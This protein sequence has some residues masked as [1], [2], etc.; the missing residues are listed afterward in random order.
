VTTSTNLKVGSYVLEALASDSS[1]NETVFSEAFNVSTNVAPLQ[2]RIVGPGTVSGPTNGEPLIVG[3]FLQLTAIPDPNQFFF[4]WSNSSGRVSL[5]PTQTFTNS[6]NLSVTA[7]FVTN[8]LPTNCVAF[9][10][11]PTN[12]FL[13]NGV[14]QL[15]GTVSTVSNLPSGPLSV[16]CQIFSGTNLL[17]ITR[18]R[19][20][21]NVGTN[22]A[23]SMGP[24][25]AGPCIAVVEAVDQAGNAT[26]VSNVFNAEVDLT[27][28][29]I[30][31]SS[32]VSPVFQTANLPIALTGNAADAHGLAALQ[33]ELFP[34][35][36]S[37]GTSPSGGG[38]AA[39][40][41]TSNWTYN[42]G[43]VPPGVYVLDAF[44][45][46]DLGNH[47][48]AAVLVTNTAVLIEGDGT[49]TLSQ[50]NVV[51]P[52]PVGYPLQTGKV[53]KMVATPA[54][55]Q[56]FV[57]WSEGAFAT[58]KST[59]TFT[60]TT[61]LLWTATF[62]PTNAKAIAISSPAANAKLKTNSFVVKGRVAAAFQSGSVKCQISSLTTGTNLLTV[63][64]TMSGANWSASIS[65]LPPDNY[66]LQ[67]TATNSAGQS[68]MDSERF[69]VL[70]FGGLAGTYTGLFLN[71]NEPV[72]PTNSGF[73]TFTLSPTGVMSGKIDFPAYQTIAI[74][75]ILVQNDFF[76]AGIMTFSLRNFH[77]GPLDG[78]INF[79][80]NGTSN[81]ATGGIAS[82]NWG[83]PLLCYQTVKTL[84]SSTAPATGKYVFTL[85]PVDQTNGPATN[86]YA[87]LTVS[88]NGALALNGALPD[89]TTF[90]E[91]GK[92]STNGVWP[93][94][95]NPT[96]DKTNGMLIGWETNASGAWSG[97]LYWYKSPGVGSYFTDGIGIASN[98]VLNATGTN[99]TPPTAGSVYS[100]VIQGG[101]AT[102]P[103][104]NSLTV[105]PG[106]Q[107]GVEDEPEDKLKISLTG[108]GALSG[109][110][111]NP[112]SG[113]ALKFKGAF[114]SPAQGGFGFVPDANGQIGTFQIQLA[115]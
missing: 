80:L 12:V 55:G 42:I 77:G 94:C 66:L 60:N 87:V 26:L 104:T 69:Y 24:I 110:F 6:T 56:T 28:P 102:P 85:Q 58:T 33:I 68:A 59:V 38:I 31:I 11:P 37:D 111:V 20:I 39:I 91:S 81:I 64:A 46:D 49:V 106:G 95:V 5:A 63:P 100:M 22:W 89:N 67:A 84:S 54:A 92:V 78:E 32:P 75:P 16:T 113:A 97:Q 51:K 15:A 109:S 74:F 17:S 52:N 96:G 61:G 7:T 25:G 70:A 29:T 8:S 76:T 18:A 99:Y 19:T 30:S 108:S 71:T 50:S 23:F 105:T 36:A 93:I 62:A 53:Y 82:S 41:A 43:I 44:A 14:V 107:F 103:L 65:N 10:L 115:P 35:P 73:I 86:G 72:A 57:G 88:P 9:T 112:A 90:S 83:S 114:V 47:N 48:G 21:T 40:P 3:S 2:L 79:S 98:Y 27:P 101:T 13:S 4:T 34:Q 45:I 1:S